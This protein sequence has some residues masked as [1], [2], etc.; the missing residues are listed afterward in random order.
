MWVMYVNIRTIIVTFS[1][2]KR[3]KSGGDRSWEFGSLVTQCSVRKGFTITAVRCR[4]YRTS[5]H[6]RKRFTITAIRGRALSCNM[7]RQKVRWNHSG[8]RPS[9]I[10]Q[11][12]TQKKSPYSKKSIINLFILTGARKQALL[13][14]EYYGTRRRCRG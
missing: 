3:K 7:T 5:C 13:L 12:D 4:D 11:H 8:T 10:L 6:V 14:T 2:G 1:L 9:I